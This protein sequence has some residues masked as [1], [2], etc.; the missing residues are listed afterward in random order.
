MSIRN[1][2]LTKIEK[3]MFYEVASVLNK[4]KGKTRGFNLALQHSHFPLNKGEVLHEVNDEQERYMLI[5]PVLQKNVPSNSQ[6]TMWR[7]SKKDKLEIIQFCC[8]R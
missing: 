7:I 2:G 5:R 3:K 6:P 1:N 8:D 4:Y